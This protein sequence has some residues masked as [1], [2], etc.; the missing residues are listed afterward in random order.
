MAGQRRPAPPRAGVQE[1]RICQQ[2][3][4]PPARCRLKASLARP[5]AD[6]GTLAKLPV[7]TTWRCRVPGGCGQP[8]PHEPLTDHPGPGI[9][10]VTVANPHPPDGRP[11]STHSPTPSALL[12][13]CSAGQA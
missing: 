4:C 1:P 12:A 5:W 6:L 10:G 8:G 13:L 3:R 9:S 7:L 2:R 11:S